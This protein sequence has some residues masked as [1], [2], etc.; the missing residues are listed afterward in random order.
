M[1]ILRT[2]LSRSVSR[3]AFILLSPITVTLIKF[4]GPRHSKTVIPPILL[5]I[6]ALT[7]F[8]F[9]VT[10][11]VLF[12]WRGRQRVNRRSLKLRVLFLTRESRVT[13]LLV[14][15]TCVVIRGQKF[16]MKM[17]LMSPSPAVI[18][19]KVRRVPARFQR[20]TRCHVHTILD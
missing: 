11:F 8:P 10:E 7:R 2:P 9:A 4:T 16:R 20:T 3:P 1:Q 14:R 6:R 12:V 13:S 5:K 19:V 18:P 15:V 17:K